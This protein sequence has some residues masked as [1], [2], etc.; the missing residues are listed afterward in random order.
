MYG[1]LIENMF[2]Y[3]LVFDTTLSDDGRSIQKVPSQVKIER[4]WLYGE[5]K[6]CSNYTLTTIS[7][8]RSMVISKHPFYIILL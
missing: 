5:S 1:L 4:C 7:G 3:F 6:E 2:F 8:K